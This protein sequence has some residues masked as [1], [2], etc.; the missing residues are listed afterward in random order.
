MIICDIFI[1]KDGNKDNSCYIIRIGWRDSE[2]VGHT[3][4]FLNYKTS[5]SPVQCQRQDGNNGIRWDDDDNPVPIPGE[6]PFSSRL[7]WIR[8]CV[9]YE[10]YMIW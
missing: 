8:F 10:V 7:K 5:S 3:T 6:A 9:T 1:L 2:T 4:V